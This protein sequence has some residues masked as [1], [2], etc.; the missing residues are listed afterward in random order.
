MSIW[1]FKTVHWKL[2][3][4][5]KTQLKDNKWQTGLRKIEWKSGRTGQKHICKWLIKSSCETSPTE[6]TRSHDPAIFFYAS[7][8]HF[9]LPWFLK[10]PIR[11]TVA[12]MLNCTFT[13]VIARSWPSWLQAFRLEGL[14]KNEFKVPMINSLC[15]WF[16]EGIV[17]FKTRYSVSHRLKDQLYWWALKLYSSSLIHILTIFYVFTAS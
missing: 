4:S 3:C 16:H 15:N 12:G 1:N 7:T 11:K 17:I 9:H 5:I 6:L 8:A 14:C 10:P 13:G 2:E